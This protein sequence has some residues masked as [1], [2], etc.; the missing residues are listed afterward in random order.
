MKREK[1]QDM[2]VVGLDIHRSFAEAAMI[3]EGRVHQ[4]G[5]IDLVRERVIAFAK[6]LGKTTD[7]VVEAT[8]NT[9]AVVKL[10]APHVRR[11][12]IAN[13]LQVRAIAH[14]KVK[15]DK[16][17]AVI[18]AKLHSAGFLPEVWQPDESTERLR[19]QV[20][21]RATIVQS[22][23]RVKNRVQSV[24]HSNLILPYKGDLFSGKGRTWLAAQPLEDDERATINGWLAELDRLAVDLR[25]VDASLASVGLGDDRVR[26]LMTITGINVT[27]AVGLV[28]AIGDVTRFTS[29][30]K[31]V[32]Y[33]GL[34]P[35]VRQSGNGRAHYGRITKH[36]RSVARGFL[37]EAAWAAAATPGPL[38]AFFIRIKARRGQQVAVVATARKIAVLV[39]HLLTKGEDY[40][41]GRPALH[42]AKL[43][44]ME[45]KA[46][47][48]SKRGGNAP[49]RARDYNIKSLRD[50]ERA[51]VAQAE[52]AYVRF[53]A[54]WNERPRA[55]KSVPKRPGCADAANEER[56]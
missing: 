38:H 16:I 28:A 24:L 36:G 12:V 21:R 44:Q 33:F 56:Q 52:G 45:I 40:A 39:W 17:D 54:A 2:R 34:N 27:V 15:T 3:D 53:V 50:V 30:E 6:R 1:E 8:G 9:M 37:V 25:Q 51:F 42:Q 19:R 26:R 47:M 49:G 5:R 10:M 35:R 20:A 22:R 29:S 13:P 41:F 4:L 11:M 18:L 32:S 43:R 7:V 31:L 14:A 48:L 23:T 55:K 46:G